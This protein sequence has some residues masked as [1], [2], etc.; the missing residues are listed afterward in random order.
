[1]TSDNTVLEGNKR[2]A[3]RF[4]EECWNTGSLVKVPEFCAAHCRFHDPAFPHMVAGVDSMQHHIERSRRAFPDMKFTIDDII[5]EGNEVVLH[6]T[7]T[8]THRDEFMGMPATNNSASIP[9]TSIY[10]FEEGKI[11]EEWANWNLMSLVEQLGLRA[12]A[13]VPAG[14]RSHV[15]WE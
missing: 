14:L 8:G 3:L 2:I 12:A 15:G 7:L 9:G 10:R 11:V 4:I 5:A 6:W 1:M 13:G